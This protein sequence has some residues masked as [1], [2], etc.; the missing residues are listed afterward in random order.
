METRGLVVCLDQC[1]PIEVVAAKVLHKVKQRIQRLSKKFKK[2][3]MAQD[4]YGQH[5]PLLDANGV[6]VENFD[7]L[8][9]WE[10]IE[11][12][13]QREADSV[14]VN[15]GLS[16]RQYKDVRAR[17]PYICTTTV[18]LAE[19]RNIK[20]QLRILVVNLGKPPQNCWNGVGDFV[21]AV[22]AISKRGFPSLAFIKH[23]TPSRPND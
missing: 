8:G 15:V 11:K 21:P 7:F 20:W 5:S 22:E 12:V 1:V 14:R 16:V 3:V 19:I 10:G 23:S 9:A 13:R 17:L 2:R 4:A 6:R 18:G